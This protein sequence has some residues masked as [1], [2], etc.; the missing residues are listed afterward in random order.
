MENR[1][2]YNFETRFISLRD[3]MRKYLKDN[4]IKY[5]LSSAGS[6]YYFEI[7]A[8]TMEVEAINTWLDNNTITGV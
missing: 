8:N 2:W 7:Y 3:G 5:E 1:K 4:S 6:Y